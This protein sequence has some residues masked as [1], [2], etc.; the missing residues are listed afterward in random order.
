V[1]LA[2]A[3]LWLVEK[4][5]IHT[6]PKSL[7]ARL[8]R[9][10][11]AM[12]D[13]GDL[14]A[15][16]MVQNNQT[17]FRVS[18]KFEECILQTEILEQL[19]KLLGNFANSLDGFGEEVNAEHARKKANK[20]QQIKEEVIQSFL[21]RPQELFGKSPRESREFAEEN[22]IPEV[23]TSPRPKTPIKQIPEEAPHILED[24]RP[25]SFSSEVRNN[26]KYSSTSGPSTA[27]SGRNRRLSLFGSDK[28]SSPSPR[29]S[30]EPSRSWKSPMGSSLKTGTERF[31]K[32]FRSSN[33][34]TKV[35]PVPETSA[36]PTDKVEGHNLT[37]LI[38]E[39]TPANGCET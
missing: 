36:C 1:A 15:T 19:A 27:V 11:L 38:P 25:T 3:S 24:Q 7:W 33:V 14:V 21:G 39:A 18:L 32:L 6:V 4:W 34:A 31:L 17:Y 16:I 26:S 22:L 8:G 23:P 2:S 9:F 5:W 12:E 28:K 30:S 13:Y 37:T 10:F 35:Q 20:L 29:E